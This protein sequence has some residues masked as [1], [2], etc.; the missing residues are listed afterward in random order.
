[1]SITSPSGYSPQFLVN[2]LISGINTQQVISALLQSYELPVTNLQNEQSQINS[3]V[4]DWQAINKD[5]AAFQTAA[6]ALATPSGWNLM[7]ASSSDTSVA[8]AT[9]TAGA[10]SGSLT[11]SVG[12]LAQA[13]ILASQNSVASTSTSIT[14]DSQYLLSKGAE[15]YGFQWLATVQGSGLALGSHSIQVTQASQAAT[16]TG[17]AAL[18]SQ[19]FT[20]SDNTLGLTVNGT[21]Y[22]LALPTGTTLSPSQIVSDLN[23]LASSA[24]APVNFSLNTSGEL[25]VSTNNQ[26]S[27]NTLEINSSTATT[28]PSTAATALNL[29]T[30]TTVSGVNAIV[31]VDGTSNTITN[32]APGGEV[33]LTSGDSSGGYIEA[34]F[35]S[36]TGPNG[37]VASLSTGT[38]SATN[39]SLGNGSL[40]DVVNNINAANAGITASAVQA[41]SGAYILQLAS[42]T[43]GTDGQITV[44]L[45]GTDAYNP[46]G[47]VLGNMDV[48]QSAQNAQISVGG[49]GGYTLSS[50]T[51]T[52]NNVMPGT[53]VTAT[54]TGS[55]TI[56]VSPDATGQATQVQSLVTA[57]NQVLSD[58]QKYA[59]YNEQTKV[60]GPL[61]GNAILQGIQNQILSTFATNG[62]TSDLGNALAAGI[63]VNSNGTIS[64]NKTTFESEFAAHPHQVAAL[65]EQ[66][67]QLP[68]GSPYVG[69]IALTYASNQTQPGTYAL[70]V[71]QPAL[72]ASDTG[73]EYYTSPTSTV[74][75][76]ETLTIGSGGTTATY[77]TTVGETLSAIAQGLNQ[78]FASKNMALSAQVADTSSGYA[79]QVTSNSY[80]SSAGFTLSSTASGTG[81]TGLAAA[82]STVYSYAGQNVAGY[83]DLNGT[84]VYGT[85][86]GQY[87]AFPTNNSQLAGLD[88]QISTP[89]TDTYPFTTNVTYVQGLSQQLSSQMYS[90]SSPVN[91]SVT[92]TINSLQ[93]Q[94]S[95]L[96]PQIAFYEQIVA[97]EKK[98]L[99]AQF[100]Q[101]EATLG[102]LKNQGAMLSSSIAQLPGL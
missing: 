31:N 93:Q 98:T 15:S 81:T 6:Q 17:T 80:G 58:I 35:A 85:G 46:F 37:S 75:T 3:Q 5:I 11:F 28:D 2:G 39:V 12:Q 102:S 10:A 8:T 97:Q 30:G 51:D 56:T 22:S 54:G 76:A 96:N 67:I 72:Q 38:V 13:E 9:A 64:F 14:T 18:A 86:N 89:S 26:G 69:Q 25:V 91:G 94:S 82:A 78:T 23:S 47:T 63:S 36:A 70:T 50:Q 61:M 4:T 16:I 53:N 83:I 24:G 43:T 57:A 42:S 21:A 20:T 99:E 34:K 44:P 68:S 27:A 32:I 65:F 41:S 84:D 52:F 95:G 73:N 59:G 79:L 100:S 29:S 62:G 33:Q 48:I 74:S 87:L 19:S 90:A 45:S 60:A 101:M 92:T 49:T 71:T 40:G 88:L 7:T 1:M 66:G 55:T 77:S